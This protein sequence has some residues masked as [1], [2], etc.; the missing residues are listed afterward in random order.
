MGIHQSTLCWALGET[1]SDG[2]VRPPCPRSTG[3]SERSTLGGGSV[4][5]RSS[6]RSEQEQTEMDVRR[7]VTVCKHWTWRDYSYQ[8][9]R[10]FQTSYQPRWHARL[11]QTKLGYIM[12]HNNASMFVPSTTFLPSWCIL[13]FDRKTWGPTRTQAKPWQGQRSKEDPWMPVTEVP[14]LPLIPASLRHDCLAFLGC[15]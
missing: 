9:E 11:W 13:E 4:H 1:L 8:Q 3:G 6:A 15:V 14:D 2:Q 10:F 7:A 5:H 12:A